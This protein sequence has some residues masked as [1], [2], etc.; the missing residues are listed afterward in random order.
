MRTNDP[1]FQY[2]TRLH[3]KT[4]P[5]KLSVDGG[6]SS[7]YS[8]K[9]LLY[10]L[11]EAKTIR[12]Q[13]DAVLSEI[14]NEGYVQVRFHG[15]SS[16]RYTYHDPSGTL[17][18]GDVVLAPSSYDKND[19]IATVVKLGKGDY[20]GRTIRTITTRLKKEVVN[21]NDED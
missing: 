10:T 1:G 20:T 3:S 4:F 19:G 11:E 6:N 17:E 18:V 13:L 16:R 14:E 9:T 5:V 7:K 21:G 2:I 12:D 8:G 15:S